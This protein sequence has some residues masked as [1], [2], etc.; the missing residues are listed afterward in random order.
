MITSMRGNPDGRGEASRGG[1]TMEDRISVDPR[2][3][4]GKPCIRGTRIMVKNILGMI[5]G[6]YTIE[7]VL[8]AYP[9]L[10]REDVVEALTYASQVIDEEKVIRRA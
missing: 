3:C 4:S 1:E 2:V 9:E 8:E 5:A 6:G 10:A 7:N